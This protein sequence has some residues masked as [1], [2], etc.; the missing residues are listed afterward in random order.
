M[1]Q[2]EQTY[3]QIDE[4]K[5]ADLDHHQDGSKSTHGFDHAEEEEKKGGSGEVVGENN[6]CQ[7]QEGRGAEDQPTQLARK[8]IG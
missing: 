8:L 5:Q 4:K 3:V 1:R 7:D 6:S 2:A